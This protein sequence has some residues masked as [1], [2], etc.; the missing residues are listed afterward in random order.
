L[1]E[2]EELNKYEVRKIPAEVDYAKINNL[3]KEAQEKLTKIKP[4]SLGQ[5]RRIGGISPSDI[6][7]LSYY[8][9]KNYLRE[10]LNGV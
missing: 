5:A 2:V 10:K 3:A 6:Q 9:N 7:M 4:I 8:L 1:K